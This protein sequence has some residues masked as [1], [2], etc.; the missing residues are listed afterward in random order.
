MGYEHWEDAV[1]GEGAGNVKHTH[2]HTHSF[3]RDAQGG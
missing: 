3:P 1:G 2:R